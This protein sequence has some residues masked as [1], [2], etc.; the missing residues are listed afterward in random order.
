MQLPAPL[1]RYVQP[2]RREFYDVKMTQDK[3][4]F[5]DGYESISLYVYLV[6]TKEEPRRRM[7]EE[8]KAK[9]RETRTRKKKQRLNGGEATN[10]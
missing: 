5:D 6:P 3:V 9:A 1:Q 10:S 2:D 7:S 8:S 4:V